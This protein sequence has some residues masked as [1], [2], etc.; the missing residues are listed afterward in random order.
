MTPPSR[1]V[2]R[3]FKQFDA[4]QRSSCGKRHRDL[5][6]WNCKKV[7]CCLSCGSFYTLASRHH[8]PLKFG[9]ETRLLQLLP[10]CE[11]SDLIGE[12]VHVRLQDNPIYEA[13]SYTWADESGIVN[14]SGNLYIKSSNM[15]M[16]ITSNCEAAL[17]RFRNELD[18]K[19]LWV[20]SICVDQQNLLERSEQVELMTRIYKQ[21]Q[22]VLVFI[23]NPLDDE[24]QDYY[25]LFD[26]IRTELRHGGGVKCLKNCIGKYFKKYFKRVPNSEKFYSIC[27]ILSIVSTDCSF[28]LRLRDT[29]VKFLSYFWFHR[30]WVI[31][32][33]IMA[34]AVTFY[35]GTFVI[36]WED[37]SLERPPPTSDWEHIT[38]YSFDFENEIDSAFISIRPDLE[39]DIPPVLRLRKEIKFTGA[40][41]IDLLSVSRTCAASDPRDKIF[42]LLGM[43]RAE[44]LPLMRADY[45]KSIK[46][47][48]IEATLYC[49]RSRKCLD[50]LCLIQSPLS[51][52]SSWVPNF[53]DTTSLSRLPRWLKKASSPP[54]IDS[55]GM[56]DVLLDNRTLDL[57][58]LDARGIL[59]DSV[60]YVQNDRKLIQHAPDSNP[61]T[62]LEEFVA[63]VRQLFRVPPGFQVPWMLL[64]C[65]RDYLKLSLPF[66]EP[67]SGVDSWDMEAIDLLAPSFENYDIQK[68]AEK[69]STYCLSTLEK[70]SRSIT[71]YG[72]GRAVFCGNNSIGIVPVGT[73][74][75]DL[76]CVLETASRPF[77]LRQKGKNYRVIGACKIIKPKLS[78]DAT[79]FHHNFGCTCR[80]CESYRAWMTTTEKPL[81]KYFCLE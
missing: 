6:P 66:I 29:L 70:L 71:K 63:L 49:I 33:V 60:T 3:E 23:G 11:D 72:R 24:L 5:Q 22:R 64:H 57:G 15:I 46:D 52:A 45:T 44:E 36:D 38:T 35:F 26:Y 74:P 17:R 76:I 41:F 58:F 4:A 67:A 48:F 79:R 39:S 62:N 31:Q 81:D 28:H 65:P 25:E 69:Y 9:D 32:E 73:E 1:D 43:A 7:E 53:S 27:S 55:L 59:L 50:I 40:K 16:K 80:S 54:K 12:L 20:D 78:C 10:G 21:A 2:Q 34:Q 30:I 8:I 13:I 61:P 19:F 42:A 77:V 56:N 51:T 14:H 18:P 75:K 47:T 37:I 68:R